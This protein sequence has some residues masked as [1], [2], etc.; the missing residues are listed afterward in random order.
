M[1]KVFHVQWCMAAWSSGMIPVLGT[2]G[3]GFNSRSGPFSKEIV[4]LTGKNLGNKNRAQ[5][6][7]NRR[8]VG[9][10]PNALPLS[11]EPM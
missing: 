10:Q 5:P 9:L 3:H 2:G 7:L 11:Y 4:I 8:P 1:L 6:E